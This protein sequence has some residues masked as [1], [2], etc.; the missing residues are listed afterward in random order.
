VDSGRGFRLKAAIGVYGSAD[1]QEADRYPG[2]VV[3]PHNQRELWTGGQD[4]L[5]DCTAAFGA[6]IIDGSSHTPDNHTSIRC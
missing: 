6:V 5:A 1:Q 3:G 2:L 4:T